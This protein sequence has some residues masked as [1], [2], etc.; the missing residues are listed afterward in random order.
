MKRSSEDIV[1]AAGLKITHVRLSALDAL[2]S[3]R[4]PLTAKAL[5]SALAKKDKTI[6]TVTV[7]R[8]LKS[9]EESGIIRSLSLGSDSLSYELAHDHHHHIVCLS[10]GLIEDFD[11]CAFDSLKSKIL[12]DSRHFKA[13]TKHSFEMFGVC[14]SCDKK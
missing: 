10:C 9:F 4:K 6:D 13:I 7:Y 2:A 1:K 8:T 12:K 3:A 11:A 14:V 5:L